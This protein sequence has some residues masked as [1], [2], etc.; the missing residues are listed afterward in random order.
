LNDILNILG[1]REVF[2]AREMT[3]IHQE[4]FRGTCSQAITKFENEVKGE[5]TVI[6][7]GDVNNGKV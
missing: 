7:K 5:L 4:F 3:K 1:D 6:I 2:I